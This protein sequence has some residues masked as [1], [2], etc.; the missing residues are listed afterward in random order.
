MLFA[1]LVVGD[2]CRTQ[3]TEAE[4]VEATV[5]AFAAAA[6]AN[7]IP[8]L[9]ATLD[10]AA[11][12]RLAAAAEHASAQIGGRRNIEP[13]EM[14]GVVGIEP[15]FQLGKVEVDDVREDR[16]TARLRAADGGVTVIELVREPEGWRVVLP[17]PGGDAGGGAGEEAAS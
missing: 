10:S 5:K 8:A 4:A 1:G 17:Q 7:D 6:W 14:L 11:L 13:H 15:T 3:Q 2:G 9:L 12:A 16:A